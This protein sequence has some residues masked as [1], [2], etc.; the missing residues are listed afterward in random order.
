MVYAGLMPSMHRPIGR[1]PNTPQGIPSMKRTLS[2]SGEPETEEAFRA[3]L[4]QALLATNR[5]T[6]ALIS[7]LRT[8]IPQ[9]AEEFISNNAGDTLLTPAKY[10]TNILLVRTIF[11]MCPNNLTDVPIGVT[12]NAST[13]TIVPANTAGSSVSPLSITATGAGTVQIKGL[14]SGAVYWENTF[15]AAGTV[16]TGPFSNITEGLSL[17]TAAAFNFTA[18]GTYQSS[19]SV[20]ITLGIKTMV[21]NVAAGDT[22]GFIMLPGLESVLLPND[23]RSILYSPALTVPNTGWLWIMGEQLPEVDF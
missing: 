15:A 8:S 17:T 5:E 14:T 21:F 7:Q 16:E 3:R 9:Y 18:N 1:E 2:T 19:Y 10:T 13:A 4:E 11:A 12:V 22:D 23:R 6:R 20:T